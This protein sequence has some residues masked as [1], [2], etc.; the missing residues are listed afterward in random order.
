MNTR[1]Q[2]YAKALAA[3]G[4]AMT[5]HQL[6][7]VMGLAKGS[8]WDRLV[9]MEKLGYVTRKPGVGPQDPAVFTLTDSGRTLA[10]RGD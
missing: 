2:E 4:G 9:A 7:S 10:I 1:R 5:K 3:N 8:A 6:A